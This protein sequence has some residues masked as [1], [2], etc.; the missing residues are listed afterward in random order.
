VYFALEKDGA[1]NVFSG[2][3]AHNA[4]AFG[5]AII[6]CLLN[7][8]SGKG[9]AI[10]DSAVLVDQEEFG[11]GRLFAR[12]GFIGPVENG[13]R[14]TVRGDGLYGNTTKDDTKQTED[15]HGGQ[16]CKVEN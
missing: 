15:S 16:L 10:I 14:K 3:K 8:G 12:A 11:D 6:Y 2:Y 13:S 4:A 7:E 9:L 1:G 5:S